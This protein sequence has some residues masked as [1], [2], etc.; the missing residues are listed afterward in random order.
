ME[1]EVE[2]SAIRVIIPA[3]NSGKYRFKKRQNNLVFG[4]SFRTRNDGFD[5][6]VYLE[7]QI[8]Y[9]TTLKDYESEVN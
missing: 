9:D 2:E 5:E 3:T 8:G 7:W 1:Y 4:E 6:S